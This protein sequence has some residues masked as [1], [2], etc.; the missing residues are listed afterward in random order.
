MDCVRATVTRTQS[1]D[2]HQY[3]ENVDDYLELFLVGMNIMRPQPLG[4]GRLRGPLPP[5]SEV[6]S[7]PVDDDI[8]DYDYK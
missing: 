4:S 3:L 6:L 8:Y 7:L 1:V 2:A 5:Q